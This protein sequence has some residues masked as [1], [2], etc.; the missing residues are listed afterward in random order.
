MTPYITTPS[1]NFAERELQISRYHP[2]LCFKMAQTHKAYGW[3]YRY[4]ADWD[5]EQRA[6]Y[7]R[8]RAQN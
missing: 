2:D 4:D 6:A 1:E 3:S 8:G 5:A 7:E